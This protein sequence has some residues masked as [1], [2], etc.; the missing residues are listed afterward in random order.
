M[1]CLLHPCLHLWGLPRII[2]G[3]GNC[4]RRIGRI[5]HRNCRIESRSRL[6][7]RLGRFFDGCAGRYNLNF[8]DDFGNGN[9]GNLKYLL[10]N[11]FMLIFRSGFPFKPNL[12]PPVRYINIRIG[13][14]FANRIGNLFCRLLVRITESGRGCL[15]EQ[16]NKGKRDYEQSHGFL[17]NVFWGGV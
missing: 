10:N 8:I 1:L 7:C 14:A 17:R 4:L 13:K 16:T 2:R 5:G 12:P 6:P 3:S 11:L 15:N 9:T